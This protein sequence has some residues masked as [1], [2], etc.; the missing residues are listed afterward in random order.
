MSDM[1]FIDQDCRRV[2]L[3]FKTDDDI[4]NGN[5]VLAIPIFQNQLLFT[6]HSK[7][8]TEFPGGKVENK[9]TS[10]QAIVRELYEETGGKI[11]D[12]HYI[13]QY[14]VHTFDNSLFK[15]D[16]YVIKVKSIEHKHDYLET[17]G[18][19][20]FHQVYEIPEHQKSYLIKDAA[21]L[22]CLERVKDLGYYKY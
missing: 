7:R 12:L 6:K 20:L 18:P 14:Q 1:E 10:Q 3:E 11:E 9:E 19:T 15:K 4:P 13:A 2:T 5:H 22:K 17:D 16:V 8:G 21:I